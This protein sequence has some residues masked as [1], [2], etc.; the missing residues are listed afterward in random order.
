MDTAHHRVRCFPDGRRCGRCPHCSVGSCQIGGCVYK[1]VSGSVAVL[2]RIADHLVQELLGQWLFALHEAK[3][4]ET[5]AGGEQRDLHGRDGL[6]LLD[7][8]RTLVTTQAWKKL[9]APF[10][11]LVDLALLTPAQREL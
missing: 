5:G 3:A 2:R 8:F 9:Y 6:E 7:P 4:G 1:K 11:G 10:P